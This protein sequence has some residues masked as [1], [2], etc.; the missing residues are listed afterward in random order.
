MLLGVHPFL[1]KK[2]LSDPSQQYSGTMKR[3]LSAKYTIP[4]DISISPEA[5]G[6]LASILVK[7]PKERLDVKGIMKHPWYREGLPENADRINQVLRDRDRSGEQSTKEMRK[8]VQQA[9]TV[10]KAKRIGM[11]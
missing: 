10:P 3:V 8:L 5:K 6:L 2:D 7:D 11:A 4:E 1:D 9:M